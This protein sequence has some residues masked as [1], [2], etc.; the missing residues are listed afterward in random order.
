MR[1][2]ILIAE[3]NAA[4][5]G[6]VR[7]ALRAHEVDCDLHVASDGSAAISFI[8]EMDADPRSP[9]LD[10]VLVDMHLPKR[11]GEDI[12]RCLRST[13]RYGQVPVVVMTGADSSIIEE[14]PTRHATKTR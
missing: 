10:L 8:R 3:D 2:N 1:F 14:K 6:L 13:E 7:E 5:V 4:D 11:D 9:L 12:L